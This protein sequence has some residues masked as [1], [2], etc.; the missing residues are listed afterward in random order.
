MKPSLALCMVHVGAGLGFSN[1]HFGHVL[2]LR[3]VEGC[4]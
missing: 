2:F 3:G 4:P 1:M